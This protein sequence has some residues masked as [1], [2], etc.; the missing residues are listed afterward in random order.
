M[1]GLELEGVE[2]IQLVYCIII[3]LSFRQEPRGP[4]NS[5]PAIAFELFSSMAR[6][7]GL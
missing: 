7:L 6:A 5:F 4:G 2:F 1:M 3:Y